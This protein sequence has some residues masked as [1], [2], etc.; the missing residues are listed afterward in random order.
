MIILLI[1]ASNSLF[2]RIF[3]I[4]PSTL[5]TNS[6]TVIFRPHNLFSSLGRS[7]YLFIFTF[8]FIWNKEI[9]HF[10]FSSYCL[11]LLGP[12]R[13]PGMGDLFG[14]QR[15]SG[16]SAFYFLWQILVCTYTSYLCDQNVVTYE[17][18]I[19]SPCLSCYAYSCLD[20]VSHYILH[21]LFYFYTVYICCYLV[22]YF[23]FDVVASLFFGHS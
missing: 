17:I 22:I 2:S 19:V 11:W 16:F 15:P 9:R 10:L 18:P 6:I 1:F 12:V 7:I 21:S 8:P 3:E 23:L 4:I 13:W 5:I 14:T 20:I